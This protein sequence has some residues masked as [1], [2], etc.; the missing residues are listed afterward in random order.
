MEKIVIRSRD[1]LTRGRAIF[2]LLLLLFGLI[3]FARYAHL[4]LVPDDAGWLRG[5]TPTVFDQYRYLPRSFFIAL[6]ATFGPNPVAALAMIFLFHSANSLLVYALCQKLWNS[7]VAA[8]VAAVVFMIN[9]ITLSTLT[10]ISC[11][12]YVQGT[13][14]ALM[15]LL[16]FWKSNEEGTERRLL[17]A[18]IALACYGLG[19]LASHA[20]LFLPV[21]FL[22]FG[23]LRGDAARRRGLLLFATAMTAGVLVNF[24][25]YGFGRYGVETS[26][27]FSLGFVSAFISSALSFGLSLA[28]AY[29]LSF[30]AKTMGF[31][32]ITFTEP[33]RWEVTL[34][35]LVGGVLLYKPGR[36][37]RLWLVLVLS[38]VAF[39]TPYIIRLYL[40][41]ASVNYHISYVLSGRVFYLPFI[42]IALILGGVAAT[43]HKHY[44]E[45]PELTKLLSLL[46][47]TVY[48]HA[49]LFLY[50][51]TDFM[52]L[53]V[54][55]GSSQNLP[56]PW[57][58][59]TDSQPAWF[60][61]SAI[62]IVAA[63]A[64]RLSGGMVNQR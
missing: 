24:F 43:A 17:W 26:K 62:I 59:Y 58:P 34:V 30:I 47:M 3:F 29:P 52:G 4:Q 18:A 56:P 11:F 15:S 20:V 2:L 41:P 12:S 55:L 21:L 48:L 22:L 7:Q 61:G 9:P 28:L 1:N 13:T 44:V 27:L 6:H 14:L 45:T 37:W 46:F 36:A 42:I 54:A 32:R 10:W 39:I 57:S 40:T 50:D 5:E 35:V 33:L 23:W 38:F 25:I 51:K 49:L 63:A 53:Q 60:I 64:L 31:L 19:L 16:A 8:R